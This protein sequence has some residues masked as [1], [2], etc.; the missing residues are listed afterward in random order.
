[1][2]NGAD[3]GSLVS[4]VPLMRWAV[5]DAEGIGRGDGFP[6][7]EAHERKA[8]EHELFAHARP[9]LGARAL[10]LGSGRICL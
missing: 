5:A 4:M 8:I 7:K 9:C 6:V 10:R 2:F 3:S 1:M